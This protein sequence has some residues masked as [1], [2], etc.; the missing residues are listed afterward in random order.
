MMHEY[1]HFCYICNSNY[2]KSAYIRR[3]RP[4]FNLIQHE[5]SNIFYRM[6]KNPKICFLQVENSK[7]TAACKWKTPK[8][9]F[10][11]VEN[12]TNFLFNTKNCTIYSQKHFFF[13]MIFCRNLLPNHSN[14]FINHKISHFLRRYALHLCTNTHIKIQIMSIYRTNIHAQ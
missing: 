8:N 11:N 6:H 14:F 1:T 3:K 10:L 4:T 7:K 2:L 5:M 12:F 13:Q 9:C